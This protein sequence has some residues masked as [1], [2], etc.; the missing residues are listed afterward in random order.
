MKLRDLLGVVA[1]GA[2]LI[3]WAPAARSGV[4]TADFE[5]VHPDPGGGFVFENIVSGGIRISPACHVHH[6]RAADSPFGFGGSSWISWDGGGCPA[7]TNPDYVGADPATNMLHVDYFDVPFTLESLYFVGPGEVTSSKGGTASGTGLM[8]FTGP[9]WTE[10]EWL[11][12]EGCDCGAPAF[13]I[14]HLTI[15][16]A[17]PLTPALFGA[18]LAAIGLLRRRKGSADGSRTGGSL[19]PPLHEE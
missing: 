8:N 17:E 5:T 16:V 19:D 1:F 10:I 13:G 14:D 6:M 18:G 3:V 15:R 11:L 4:I 12:F 2:A 7:D 9:E